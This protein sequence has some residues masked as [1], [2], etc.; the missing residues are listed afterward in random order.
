MNHNGPRKLNN[1]TAT[2]HEIQHMHFNGTQKHL[3]HVIA[4]DNTDEWYGLFFIPLIAC[5]HSPILNH[6]SIL[7][8]LP[9]KQKFLANCIK[10]FR[11]AAIYSTHSW[12]GSWQQSN[13]ACKY[14]YVILYVNH[15]MIDKMRLAKLFS[16]SIGSCQFLDKV[17]K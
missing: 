8:L 6:V 13:L 7:L 14:T 10:R 5:P 11:T 16:V 3:K 9:K 1:W 17:K 15:T 4:T 12:H 2:S